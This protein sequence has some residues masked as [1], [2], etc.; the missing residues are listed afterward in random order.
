MKSAL[1]IAV[2]LL[3]SA[4]AR[5]DSTWPAEC[6][7]EEGGFTYTQGEAQSCSGPVAAIVATRRTLLKHPGSYSDSLPAMITEL[8]RCVERSRKQEADRIAF[9][10]AAASDLRNTQ[11]IIAERREANAQFEARRQ[12]EAAAPAPAVDK[13]ESQTEDADA[14]PVA[15]APT[16]LPTPLRKK[17]SEAARKQA[18]ARRAARE[19]KHA[20]NEAKKA[21]AVALVQRVSDEFCGA[22]PERRAWNGIY[23]GLE[24]AFKGVANDP[25]SVEFAGC[26][27]LVKKG[28]PACWM[29]G[30]RVREKNRYGARILK[31]IVFSKSHLGWRL[32]GER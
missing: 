32:L 24:D 3:F 20:E 2:L 28:P 15:V 21:E 26:V 7:C 10:T 31:E 4:R 11:A 9:D 25:D 5:A 12:A 16:Q 6:P 29:T 8:R 1:A 30:C 22:P 19:A 23:Q 14:A 13:P 27:D 18:A 17:T